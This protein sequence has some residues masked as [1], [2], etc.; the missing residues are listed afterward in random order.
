MHS[1]E[2]WHFWWSWVTFEGHFWKF[3]VVTLCAQ[4]TRARPVSND[5]IYIIKMAAAAV[6]YY[7]RF[8]IW[9]HHSHPK[10]KIYPQTKFR[11]GILIHGWD[12]TA[13]LLPVWKNKR[14][15]YWNSSS[16]CDF[17]QIAVNRPNRATHGGVMT[18]Y[19]ISRWR[20]RL[21]TTSGFVLDDVTLFR[22]STSISKPNFIDILIHG[23]EITTSG[24]EKQSSAILKFYFRFQ[25]WS[26]ISSYNRHVTLH[27]VVEF[28]PKWSILCGDVT[29]YRFSRW[30]PLRR[31][32]TSG[33]RSGDVALFRMSVSISEPNFVV[34]T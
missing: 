25:F 4:L 9:W 10:V 16:L 34:I 26:S 8:R 2:H 6:P 22:R 17:D 31:N 11:R 18:S 19:T 20:P 29:L 15:P 23:W 3:T 14:P 30:R 24:L 32:Y 5:I 27:S 1:V 33:F 28:R 13:S 12:I 21:H 7:F